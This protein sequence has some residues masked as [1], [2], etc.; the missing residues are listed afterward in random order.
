M[1]KYV[2]VSPEFE[3]EMIFGYDSE[4]VL[5]YYENNAELKHEHMIWLSRNFP[6][7]AKDLP[8]IVRKGK[9]TEIT[10][11]S[12]ARFWKD[13]GLKVG[14]KKRA[15]KLW[16]A[17]SESERIAVFEHLPRYNYYLKTHQGL[18]KAYPETFLSQ[19]RW[20]NEYR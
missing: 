7:T 4:E 6:F 20:E 5:I 9:I 14:N 12:F 17:L 2:V 11:L 10:D 8:K 15:E 3:G 13:Y 1:R 19:R 16:I 18:M